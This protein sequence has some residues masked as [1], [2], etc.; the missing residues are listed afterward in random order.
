MQSDFAAAADSRSAAGNR[1]DP[2]RM[3]GRIEE[4]QQ[5]VAGNRRCADIHQGMKVK[6]RMRHQGCIEHHRDAA[7]GVIDDGERGH[8][9]G[10]DAK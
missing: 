8:R 9:A 7:R 5:P 10:R 4:L 2:W 3:A 6:H 1:L